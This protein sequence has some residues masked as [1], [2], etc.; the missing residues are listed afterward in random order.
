MKLLESI[1]DLD[2][3]CIL[4]IALLLNGMHKSVKFM[5]IVWSVELQDEWKQGK[6]SGEA[7]KSSLMH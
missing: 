7:S 2:Y 3:V 5:E 6:H 1:A 4:G